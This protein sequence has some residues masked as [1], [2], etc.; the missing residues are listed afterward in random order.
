MATQSFFGGRD[1]KADAAAPR[2]EPARPASEPDFKPSV[3]QVANATLSAAMEGG[4][5]LIVGPDIKLKGVEIT[6]CDTLIVEGIVQ[7]SMNARV[8]QIAERGQFKGAAEFDLVD[9]R[10]TFDGDLT[11]RQTLAIHSTGKVTG[12]IRYRWIMVEEGG[13]LSGDVGLRAG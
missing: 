3:S 10:G 9:I 2:T 5:K 1:A 7:A 13:Q 11:V 8:M 4:S 12:K 6:D